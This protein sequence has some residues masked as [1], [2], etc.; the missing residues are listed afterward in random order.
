MR[1]VAPAADEVREVAQVGRS[2]GLAHTCRTMLQ[3]RS[4]TKVGDRLTRRS[5]PAM[6]CVSGARV[7][8]EAAPARRRLC[9]ESSHA[10]FRA[11]SESHTPRHGARP[12]GLN[13]SFHE[14]FPWGHGF[15]PSRR[16]RSPAI[17]YGCTV[18]PTTVA[19]RA[20]SDRN[21]CVLTAPPLAARTCLSWLHGTGATEKGTREASLGGFRT[22]P[23]LVLPGPAPDR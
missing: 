19:P 17:Q 2:R 4:Q 3:A 21:F 7:P 12:A 5:A 11:G 18:L 15:R 10:S 8:A 1:T 22:R 9:C 6:R 13:T 20:N 16:G 14:L 23:V